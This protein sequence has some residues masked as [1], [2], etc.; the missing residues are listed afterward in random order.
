MIPHL[1]FVSFLHRYLGDTIYLS[2]SKYHEI[3][4]EEHFSNSKIYYYCNMDEDYINTLV[5]YLNT[6]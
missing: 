5:E 6:H 1:H 4:V 2:K 3:D